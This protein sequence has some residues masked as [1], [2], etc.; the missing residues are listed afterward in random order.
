[1]LK[2]IGEWCLLAM[3]FLPVAAIGQVTRDILKL[4][5]VVTAPQSNTYGTGSAT[6]VSI[7]SYVFETWMDGVSVTFGPAYRRYMTN[8]GGCC[9]EGPV[10]LPSGASIT[11]FEMVGCDTTAGGSIVAAFYSV[12]TSGAPTTI[13]F[14]N[15]GFLATPGCAAFGVDI[16]PAV[17]VNNATTSY[18]IEYNQNGDFSGAV[19]LV[20][21]RILYKLQVSPAPATA[22]FADVSNAHPLYQ[23]IEAL[24]ASG[25]TAGCT[26]PPNP[27][28]CP[29]DFLTR[30]QMAV[31]LARGL[32]LHWAP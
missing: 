26:A 12:D 27:N 20:G 18:G 14:L 16:S 13:G 11:R 2:F 28:Y 9:M 23:F 21:A 25:I 30:G 5:E 15:S 22:T 8:N 29:N 17:T 31:F 19:S 6:A 32:G 10:S 24:A 3:L 1:M 7:N 4:P